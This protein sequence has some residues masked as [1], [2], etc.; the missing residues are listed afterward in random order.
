M[1][2]FNGL[3][4]H[5]FR[6]AYLQ[7][8]VYRLLCEQAREHPQVNKKSARWQTH[9]VGARKCG[10]REKETERRQTN[11]KTHGYK[12]ICRIYMYDEYMTNKTRAC[13]KQ[14]L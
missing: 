13:A 3:E 7:T 1:R 4:T 10:E 12:V 11:E 14:Q 8:N 9:A 5:A 6:F 2:G